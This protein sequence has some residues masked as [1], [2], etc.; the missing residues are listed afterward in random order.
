MEKQVIIPLNLELKTCNSK[1]CNKSCI[2]IGNKLLIFT[3]EVLYLIDLSNNIL[4]FQRQ[5]GIAYNQVK[6]LDYD[7]YYAM[8]LFSGYR[9]EDIYIA[10]MSMNNGKF[11]FSYNILAKYIT[12]IDGEYIFHG[13][14]RITILS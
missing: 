13:N 14:K 5:V 3:E 10:K 7:D 11:R 9:E 4:I 1:S 12:D 6:L 2:F 8:L